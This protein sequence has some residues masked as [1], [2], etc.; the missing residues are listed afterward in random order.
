MAATHKL[1]A[2]V[3]KTSDLGT[4]VLMC[5]IIKIYGLS[6]DGLQEFCCGTLLNTSLQTTRFLR[7]W[8]YCTI[9]SFNLSEHL[10]DMKCKNSDAGES[11][12]RK[13]TTSAN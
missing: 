12:V 1:E 2:P 5:Q 7:M 13:H 4:T 11:P 6:D 9:N 3:S 10:N 8:E